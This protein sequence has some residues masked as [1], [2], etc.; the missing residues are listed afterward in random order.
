MGPAWVTA[1]SEVGGSDP[2]VPG[3]LA[4]GCLSGCVGRSVS[5]ARTLAFFLCTRQDV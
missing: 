4:A 3:I 2:S 5:V 1:W